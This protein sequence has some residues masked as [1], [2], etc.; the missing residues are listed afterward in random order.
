MAIDTRVLCS[1]PHSGESP[2]LSAQVSQEQGRV[3][4]VVH[5]ELDLAS[6]PA[7][8]QELAGL[9]RLDVA[10]MTLDLADL[11]FI[12]SSGLH[13]LNAIREL[14][15]GQGV[16]L[17]LRALPRHA[18]RVLDITGMGSLFTIAA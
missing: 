13:A 11:S 18:R 2:V 7:L 17:E 3:T 1:P 4:V 14:A 8:R 12:D 15:T 10:T 6:A 9:L 5:G 16:R